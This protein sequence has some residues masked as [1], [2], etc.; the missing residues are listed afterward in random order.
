[1]GKNRSLRTVAFAPMKIERRK[2]TE[3]PSEATAQIIV[4]KLSFISR[5]LVGSYKFG[6]RSCVPKKITCKKNAMLYK[7][8]WQYTYVSFKWLVQSSNWS[9]PNTFLFIA[10]CPDTHF[11]AYRK[12]PNKQPCSEIKLN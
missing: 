8:K 9:S 10:G 3:G 5:Y 2:R 6:I 7:F 12:A 1:M 4:V 11:L